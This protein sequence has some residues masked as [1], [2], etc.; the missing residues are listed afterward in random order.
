MHL[1]C[2]QLPHSCIHARTLAYRTLALE[3][4]CLSEEQQKHRVHEIVL[5]VL[6]HCLKQL[7]HQEQRE[8]ILLVSHDRHSCNQGHQ[9]RLQG[10]ERGL[11]W[12]Y[13]DT[14]SLWT[15]TARESDQL[16][17]PVKKMPY[18]NFELIQAHL[19]CF[20]THLPYKVLVQP[21]IVYFVWVLISP[22]GYIYLAEGRRS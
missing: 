12:W 19:L 11:Q 3:L 20:F 14:R 2:N 4:Q 15:A 10:G 13:W 5:T 22:W 16:T 21:I 1:C 18:T 7:L 9:Q 6:V 8:E 17:Q